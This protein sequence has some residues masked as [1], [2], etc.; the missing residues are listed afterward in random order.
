MADFQGT[1]SYTEDQYRELKSITDTDSEPADVESIITTD[2]VENLIKLSSISLVIATIAFIIIILCISCLRRRR[3]KKSSVENQVKLRFD[4]RNRTW[5]LIIFFQV[6]IFTISK[7]S[8]LTE[9][10]PPSYSSLYYCNEIDEQPPSYTQAVKMQEGRW[11]YTHR[12]N[13]AY[14]RYASD[15]ADE[16]NANFSRCRG[17]MLPG[18]R[19]FY[20]FHNCLSLSQ[21]RKHYLK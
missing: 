6:E 13:I 4:N 1:N 7:C 10:L 16:V 21:L 18:H 17:S 8:R 2:M 3:S 12:T 14:M 15:A 20:Q 11:K 9:D 19:S 5:H